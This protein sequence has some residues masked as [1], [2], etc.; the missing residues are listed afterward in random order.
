MS[1]SFIE[2]KLW[3]CN[4]A[5]DQKNFLEGLWQG[6]LE[7]LNASLHHLFHM[8]WYD[9]WIILLM[10]TYIEGKQKSFILFQYRF[11][12]NNINL[13]YI[14]GKRNILRNISFFSQ[15]VD[16]SKGKLSRWTI[17]NWERG[18]S[19]SAFRTGLCGCPF[20]QLIYLLLHPP[21]GIPLGEKNHLIALDWAN[22]SNNNQI[23]NDNKN[24]IDGGKQDSS[25]WMWIQ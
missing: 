12:C 5:F 3:D 22:C 20:P 11:S 23:E 16:H 8:D 9:E 4:F 25:N 7:F 18:A 10:I 24:T 17:Y 6:N 15:V 13:L 14:T 19:R 1:R 21:K 2:E